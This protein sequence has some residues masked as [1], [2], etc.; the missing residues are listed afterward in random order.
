VSLK[1]L[2]SNSPKIVF[3]DAGEGVEMKFRPM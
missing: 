3:K 2:A 1:N